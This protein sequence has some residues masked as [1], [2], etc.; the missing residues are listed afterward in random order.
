[1]VLHL[2]DLVFNSGTFGI[3]RIANRASLLGGSVL[4]CISII[5]GVGWRIK[6]EIGGCSM[7]KVLS[8]SQIHAF[9]EEFIPVFQS[10]RDAKDTAELLDDFGFGGSGADGYVG[11]VQAAL[12]DEEYFLVDV[13]GKI[14]EKHFA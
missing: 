11:S 3:H 9:A 10:Y 13:L 4:S 6:E 7:S 1:M 8:E 14:I 2:R 5:C 12:A